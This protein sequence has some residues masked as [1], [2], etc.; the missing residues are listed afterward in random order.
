MKCKTKN[1][2]N[3]ARKKRRFC[4]KCE[5]RKG[6]EKNPTAAT[7]RNLKTNA[8]RRGIEFKLTLEEFFIFCEETGYMKHKG[9]EA[10]SMT[11]DRKR[12]W[13]GYHKDNLQ[14]LTLSENVKKGKKEKNLKR[15]KEPYVVPP[16][17]PF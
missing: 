8:K 6:R 1:C 14:V 4:Y 13:E 16:G 17:M 9:T 7:Y 2:Y 3:E 10:D 12:H 5:K 11:I 15:P